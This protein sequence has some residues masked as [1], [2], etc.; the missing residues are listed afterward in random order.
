MAFGKW[1]GG[2]VGW[3][4]GGPIGAFLGFALGSIFDRAEPGMV[5][6]A[7]YTHSTGRPQTRQGDFNI[8]LVIL[9]AA[10][11]KAD[12]RTMKSELTYVKSFLDQQF[13]KRASTEYIR[14][15]RDI[16][17]KDIPVR[18]V[19]QQIAQYMAMP[20]RLQLLHYLYGIAKA[21][22]HVHSAEVDLI[23]T[24]ASYMRIPRADQESIK[25]MFYQEVNSAYKI[26][27]I[28]PS[29]SNDELK[30]AYRRMAKR[31]HPDKV[32]SLGDEVRQGAE[33]KF[34][35]IQEAYEQIK[36]ERGLN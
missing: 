32:A 29:V 4:F 12:G 25:N 34:K 30:Q 28:D 9:S 8:S 7:P 17:K 26:L 3:A 31:F 21:D 33:E 24:I 22:G 35:K 10:V 36:K 16:L 11:M 18:E 20:M 19:S 15:L 1:I 5:E 27:E 14:M 2:A 13:G 23:S 6:Q